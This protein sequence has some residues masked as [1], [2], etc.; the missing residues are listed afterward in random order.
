MKQFYSI[1]L[2]FVIITTL[3]TAQSVYELNT[4]RIKLPLDNRGVVGEVT[5]NG[6]SGVKYD[7]ISTIYSSGFALSGMRNSTLWANGVMTAARVADFIP[8]K[9]GTPS[10]DP[11]NRLYVVSLNDPAFGTSWQNWSDAVALG[12]RYWDGNN[13]GIYNPQ[14]LNNNGKW[15]IN[16]DMPEILGEVSVWCIFNDAADTAVRKF[17]DVLPMGIE[18]MQTVYA[19]PHSDVAE[20]RDAVFFRYEV[21]NT[22]SVVQDLSD[23]IF[24]M[25]SDTDLGNYS[26]DLTGTDVARNS[27]YYYNRTPDSQFGNNPPAVFHSFLLGTPVFIPGETF[28]DNNNNGVY[29]PGTDIPLDS[30][31]LHFGK[32]FAKQ[33]VP[34]A[35]NTGV[36]GSIMFLS[37]HPTQGDFLTTSQLRNYMEGKRPSGDPMDPCNWQWGEVRG[38]VPCAGID[39]RLIYS[40]DPVANT[41]WIDNHLA[42]KRNIV[43][44]GRFNLS[45]GSTATFHTGLIIGRGSDQFNSITVTR[46]AYDTILTRVHLG[47]ADVPLGVEETAGTLPRGFTLEQN[48]P[49]PFN[50]ETVIRFSLPATSYAKGVVY[51]ILGREVATLIDGETAAGSHQ[52]KFNAAGLPSGVYIFRLE[53][54]N[55]SAAI[56]MVVNK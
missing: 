50:P 53:T 36:T 46:A 26:D 16:E 6:S 37:S 44:S 8:G 38:G 42:D 52:L 54:A 3:L 56:K 40:G 39:N 47:T 9:A 11:K 25:Y 30:A 22:G 28:T 43:S 21:K 29:D 18:V 5:V 27:A 24:G 2:L 23:M 33:Y 14:D 17:K 34:G 55:H 48:H 41:G 4:G 15:D 31:V 45:A 51:D 49:N 32:P 1:T 13:D 12:A 35:K 20:I 10:N 19:F 7:G